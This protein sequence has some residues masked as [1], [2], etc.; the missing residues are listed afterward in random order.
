MTHSHQS[1]NTWRAQHQG[2]EMAQK[3]PGTLCA[4]SQPGFENNLELIA[5]LSN[6]C[7]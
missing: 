4:Q 6:T 7:S 1:L 2:Q 5:G 3:V